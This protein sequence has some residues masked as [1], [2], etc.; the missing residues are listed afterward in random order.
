MAAGATGLHL[1]VD[2][3]AINALATSAPAGQSL[4]LPLAVLG[5]LVNRGLPSDEALA[6]VRERLAARARNTD[7]AEL[8]G[9]FGRVLPADRTPVDIG[10]VGGG[11][12]VEAG[13]TRHP[14]GAPPNVPANRGQAGGRPGQQGRGAQRPGA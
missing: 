8:P 5:A 12:P 14:P 10:R 4:V 11:R 9:R 3:G 7:L 13:A 1:G 2:G 6:A